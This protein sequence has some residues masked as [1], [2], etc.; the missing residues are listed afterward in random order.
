[1][2]SYKSWSG[3]NKQLADRLC[4]PLKGRITYFLTRYHKVHNA[5]GRA[6]I[7]LDGK[8]LVSFAWNEKY[9][10]DRDVKERWE[11]TGVWDYEAPELKEKWNLE[12]TLTDYDFLE[13]ATEFLQLSIQDALQSKNYLIRV[14]A[15]M[16]KRVGKRT[17]EAIRQ[18][19]E[20]TTYPEWVRQF[21][22]LRMNSSV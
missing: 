10:Q 1:M 20:Y 4:E 22:E 2:N 11:K 16:D 3:L 14:F 19:G 9:K 21:Y 15:I 13:A 12:A 17:L 6:S 18:A 8:E 7:R 5:Y